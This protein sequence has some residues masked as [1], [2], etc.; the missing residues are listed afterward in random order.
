MRSGGGGGGVSQR[1]FSADLHIT[2]YFVISHYTYY[3]RSSSSRVPNIGISH[4]RAHAYSE[5]R[6]RG[7]VLG[8]FALDASR[9]Y[10][11]PFSDDRFYYN[12]NNNN[13]NDNNRPVN[14]CQ[15][16]ELIVTPPPDPFVTRI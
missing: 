11:L 16:T 8:E 1:V 7:T 13:N 3:H 14:V 9:S 15:G 12:L 2:H 4:G 10:F 5:A 6:R